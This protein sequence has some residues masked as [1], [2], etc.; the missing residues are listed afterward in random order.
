MCSVTPLQCHKEIVK[1]YWSDG[2]TI[3]PLL[4]TDVFSDKRTPRAWILSALKSM[5]DGQAY[6]CTVHRSV[7][8]SSDGPW[9]TEMFVFTLNFIFGLT[10]VRSEYALSWTD[11]RSVRSG[12]LD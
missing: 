3:L 5:R 10:P 1:R 4:S 7:R 12:H 9:I 8:C 11:P 6:V 2:V